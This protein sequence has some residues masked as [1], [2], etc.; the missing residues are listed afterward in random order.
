HRASWQPRL[1]S[2]RKLGCCP[3]ERL[4]ES[5]NQSY[6]NDGRTLYSHRGQRNRSLNQPVRPP[7][8]ADSVG[9]RR[10]CE[11]AHELS[12]IFRAVSSGRASRLVID[13]WI[14]A[15]R[16]FFERL[17]AAIARPLK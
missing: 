6:D 8:G 14:P 4:G 12:K 15:N 11:R 16:K 7:R 3:S 13:R 9:L 5:W 10:P 1:H 17:S 2:H